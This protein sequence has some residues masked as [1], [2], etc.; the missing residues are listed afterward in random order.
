EDQ[1]EDEEDASASEKPGE[2]NAEGKCYPKGYEPGDDFPGY[3]GPDGGTGEQGTGEMNGVSP[4][5]HLLPRSRPPASARA[6]SPSSSG[7]WPWPRSATPGRCLSRPGRRRP[8]TS[9][10]R[11]RPERASCGAPISRNR[12]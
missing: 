2:P 11:I 12:C 3:P 1:T 9:V 6:A 4:L 5:G 8:S 7:S 10:T